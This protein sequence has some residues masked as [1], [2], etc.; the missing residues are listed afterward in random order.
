MIYVNLIQNIKVHEYGDLTNGLFVISN[1]IKIYFLIIWYGKGCTS[2]GAHFDPY[3]KSHG[4]PE[5]DE[6][7]LGDLGNVVANENG[8]SKF[9]F[10]DR[11]IKLSGPNS[12]VGRA[13]VIHGDPDDLGLGN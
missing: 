2:A 12:I 4:S 5:M 7:H 1:Q 11:L 9:E 6:R 8:L 3:N 13:L 10:N